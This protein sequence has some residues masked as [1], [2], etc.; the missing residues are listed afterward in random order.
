M[1]GLWCYLSELGSGTDPTE[2]VL[3]I[4]ILAGISRCHMCCYDIIAGEEVCT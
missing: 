3:A 2:G 1:I 4:A